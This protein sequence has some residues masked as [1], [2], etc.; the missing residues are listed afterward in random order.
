MYITKTNNR[1]ICITVQNNKT[2]DTEPL[3]SDAEVLYHLSQLLKGGRVM[4]IK[5]DGSGDDGG[6]DNVSLDGNYVSRLW[7]NNCQVH[8][9]DIGYLLTDLVSDHTNIIIDYNNE[10][11]KGTLFVREQEEKLIVDCEHIYGAEEQSIY[12]ELYQQVSLNHTIMKFYKDLQEGRPVYPKK[13]NELGNLLYLLG[14]KKLK[15]SKEAYDSKV[16]IDALIMKDKQEDEESKLDK[17]Q[18]INLVGNYLDQREDGLALSDV[19]LISSVTQQ[20]RI[21]ECGFSL[22]YA[23]SESDYEIII[24]GAITED[25]SEPVTDQLVINLKRQSV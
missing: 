18:I 8:T 11:C 23:C 20:E 5:Y 3:L 9:S 19:R 21:Y 13:A 14:I 16:C 25:E 10:G 24:E 7:L 1:E 12:T 17:N 22:D 6:I 2:S 15:M 4:E